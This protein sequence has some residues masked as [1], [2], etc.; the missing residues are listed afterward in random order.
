MLLL[1]TACNQSLAF[2]VCKYYYWYYYY[3]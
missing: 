2:F 3:Y 1:G